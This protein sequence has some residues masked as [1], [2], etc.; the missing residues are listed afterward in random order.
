MAEPTSPPTEEAPAVPVLP[1]SPEKKKAEDAFAAPDGDVIEADVR[2]LLEEMASTFKSFSETVFAKSKS[3]LD[4]FLPL[5]SSGGKAHLFIP[6][7]VVDSISEKV[8]A[9]QTSVDVLPKDEGEGG[10]AG[11]VKAV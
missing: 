11:S 7:F 3:S 9:L 10:Q 2:N 5:L 4:P 6:A 8:E 1:E